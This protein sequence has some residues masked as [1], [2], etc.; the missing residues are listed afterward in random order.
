M[1]FRSKI[2]KVQ[3]LTK[4]IIFQ[5]HC[6]NGHFMPNFD[7][8]MPGSFAKKFFHL[9]NSKISLGL[10]KMLEQIT[11]RNSANTDR[12]ASMLPTCYQ[13]VACMLPACSQHDASMLPACCQHVTSMLP[14]CYQHVASMLIAFA[15]H[16]QSRCKE[17]AAFEEQCKY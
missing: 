10:L 8:T 6:I 2:T 16:V 7:L 9:T 3:I 17:D 5:L 13:H 4:L 12:V 15:E 11:L 1:I 14:A